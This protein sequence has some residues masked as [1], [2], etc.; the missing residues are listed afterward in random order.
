MVHYILTT[1]REHV[2]ATAES[3]ADA[4]K[5]AIRIVKIA[6]PRYGVYIR[7]NATVYKNRPMTT[8]NGEL[9]RAYGPVS[10]QSFGKIVGVVKYING[11]L[12]Y[13]PWKH[14]KDGD[15]TFQNLEP[16]KKTSSRSKKR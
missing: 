7:K 8:V 6:N 14:N 9:K 15:Y 3:L 4:K 16:K 12:M 2:V 13:C 10:E 5:K 1:D 11:K